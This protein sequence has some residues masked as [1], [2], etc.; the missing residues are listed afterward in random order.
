MTR[1]DFVALAETIRFLDLPRNARVIVA[2]D[3]ADTLARGN[4]AFDKERFINDSTESTAIDKKEA[5]RAKDDS[6]DVDRFTMSIR[7]ENDAFS[8]G[9]HIELAR[10]LCDTAGRLSRGELKVGSSATL[11]DVNGNDVGRATLCLRGVN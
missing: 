8:M 1:K 9:L 10:I 11:R 7:T 2:R 6:M 3:F 4:R 5:T